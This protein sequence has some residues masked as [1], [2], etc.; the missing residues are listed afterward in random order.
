MESTISLANQPRPNR[1]PM[2]NGLE[3][4]ANPEYFERDG[5]FSEKACVYF[6]GGCGLIKIGITCD[7]D[8][9]WRQ[10]CNLCPMELEHLGFVQGTKHLER[11]LHKR[12]KESRRHGEWFVETPELIAYIESAVHPLWHRRKPS[13]T[14]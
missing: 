9:R 11:E 8:A 4:T 10:I 14:A 12:F 2:G 3:T 5:L 6:I 13:I 1:D 7:V